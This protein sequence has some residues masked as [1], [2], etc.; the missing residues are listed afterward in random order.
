MSAVL[1]HALQR[2]GLDVVMVVEEDDVVLRMPKS[3]ADD[4]AERLLRTVPLREKQRL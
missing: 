2:I 3:V 4:V 1:M